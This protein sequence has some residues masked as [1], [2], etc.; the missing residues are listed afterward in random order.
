MKH[1]EGVRRL[2]EQLMKRLLALR[3]V[4]SD[5]T[6]IGINGATPGSIECSPFNDPRPD[7]VEMMREVRDTTEKDRFPN[8]H[9]YANDADLASWISPGDA[10]IDEL[11]WI[12]DGRE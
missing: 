9:R 10:L 8:V 1:P 12:A 11:R 7:M 3:K 4:P 5:P 2:A 6:R